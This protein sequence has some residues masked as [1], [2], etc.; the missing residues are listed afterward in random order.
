MLGACSVPSK[1]GPKVYKFTLAAIDGHSVASS[2]VKFL[3]FGGSRGAVR[4]RNLLPEAKR[5]SGARRAASKPKSEVKK[6]GSKRSGSK[7]SSSR[8]DGPAW[9]P[10]ASDSDLRALDTRR[11]AHIRLM[12]PGTKVCAPHVGPLTDM[13]HLPVCMIDCMQVPA[14]Q[15]AASCIV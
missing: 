12:F 1:D 4:R 9:G 10:V 2:H 11:H 13:F 15:Y 5:P 3:H 8:P 7:G 14:L 6:E